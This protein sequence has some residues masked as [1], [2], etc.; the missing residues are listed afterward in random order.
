MNF[1]EY[2]NVDFS[3]SKNIILENVSFSIKNKGQTICLLGPSGVGKTTILR[4]IAGLKYINNGEIVLNEKIL[5]NNKIFIEPE[6]RNVS[7]SFQD[8][9]L[10]PHFDIE[11]NIKLAISK[12]NNGP[13]FFSTDELMDLFFIKHLKKKYPHE[14]SA[15]EAQRACVIRSISKNPDLLLLDEPF[16]NLDQN[17]KEIVQKNL[18]D[19]LKKTSITTIIVTHDKKEAF[20]FGDYCGVLLNKKFEQFDTPF[21]LHY[22]PQTKKI[23]EFF[24]RGT[25]IPVKVIKKNTLYNDDLGEINADVPST[26]SIN[27]SFEILIQPEDLHFD[28]T[29][30]LQLDI[31]DR[32]FN[33]TNSTYILNTK[34]NKKISASVVSDHYRILEESKKFGIKKPI[35]INNLICF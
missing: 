28:E 12:N 6:K 4:T 11:K 10:F 1:F 21:N 20:Y 3:N 14:I 32:K 9:A 33:G 22:K 31:I 5:S 30:S 18:K 23:L 26:F 15:G 2:K 24:N 7:L 35:Y 19:I 29:S 17:L 27:Q 16:A 25:L 13:L 34:N 8:N